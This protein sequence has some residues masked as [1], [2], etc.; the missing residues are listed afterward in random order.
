M[1]IA[2]TEDYLLDKQVKILQPVNG[3]RASSDAVLLAAMISHVENDTK[4]LDVGSGTGAVS[5]CLAQRLLDKDINIEGFELQ[6][7]LVEL[8]NLS[9]V[10]N[11]FDFLHFRQIDIRQKLSFSDVKP[12]SFDV[13]ISN[14][15]YS[16]H[17]M[18]SPN[19]S[20]AAAHNHQNFGL[21][22]WLDFCLKMA[23]PFGRICLVH[24]AEALPQIC[25]ALQHK[26]GEITV[27]PLYSKIGQNAKRIIVS[28]KKDS[29][30]VC[31]ILPPFIMHDIDGKYTQQAEKI[32]RKG[33]TFEDIFSV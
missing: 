16:E 14:P 33:L 28:A 25:T 30:A 18:P 22:Q 9:A 8:S 31:R 2:Y 26:A 3:Y 17:D 11:G 23:K 12:C 4:I 29:K 27:L 6:P 1:T 32:L 10:A 24:R 5:L 15:P 20:K 13:V 7:E 21:T 19:S